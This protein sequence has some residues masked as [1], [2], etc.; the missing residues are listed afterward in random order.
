MQSI[1]GALGGAKPP[2]P[3]AGG[4]PTGAPPNLGGATAPQGNP[5]NVIS[6]KMKLRTAVKMIEDVLPSIPMGDPLHTATLK[7]VSDLLK[8]MPEDSP[9]MQGPQTVGL[10]QMLKQASAS[11]PQSMLAKLGG[12]A[13][14]GGAQPPVMP[15]GGGEPP[16]AMAA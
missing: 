7:A 5:G 14:A 8:A 6:A 10:L 3:G 13:P 11:A 4:L 1:L 9:D 12:A 2:M 16:P 15:P